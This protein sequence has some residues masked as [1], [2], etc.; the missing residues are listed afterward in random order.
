[1]TRRSQQVSFSYKRIFQCNAFFFLDL[2]KFLFWFVLCFF[3]DDE[4]YLFE[5]QRIN[6]MGVQ[7]TNIMNLKEFQII[8]SCRR[9]SFLLINILINTST[10]NIFMQP[11]IFYS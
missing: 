6:L 2:M 1:M 10:E 3:Y 5:N 7:S 4:F 11:F 8:Y 9:R